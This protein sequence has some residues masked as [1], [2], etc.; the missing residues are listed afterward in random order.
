MPVEESEDGQAQ[1]RPIG[2]A[3]GRDVLFEGAQGT[4]LDVDHGTYPFVTSSNTVA[5]NATCGSGI[6]PAQIQSVVGVTK[7]YTTRVGSGPFP[8]ELNDAVGDH[9]RKEGGE[10]GATT[11][12]FGYKVRGI[13]E[14]AD[15]VAARTHLNERRA[16]RHEDQACCSSG[17]SLPCRS[18]VWMSSLPPTCLSPMKICGTVRRPFARSVMRRRASAS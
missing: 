8:T 11:G 12:R 18:S 6:G 15:H 7:A 17:S 9:L 4:S 14:I 10:F 1:I 13:G 3:A 16:D 2:V 5:G